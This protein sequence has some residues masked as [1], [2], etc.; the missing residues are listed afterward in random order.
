MG[1]GIMEGIILLTTIPGIIG[2]C[3]GLTVQHR[4]NVKLLKKA[5]YEIE[6]DFLK[7]KGGPW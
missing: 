5:G 6:A 1:N 7:Y 3:I 2:F 4:A